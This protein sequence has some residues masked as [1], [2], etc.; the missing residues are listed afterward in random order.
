MNCL[1]VGNIDFPCN[2][3]LAILT[4]R[5][6]GIPPPAGTVFKALGNF[7]PV[8][9]RLLAIS[10]MSAA[11]TQLTIDI[12]ER[13]AFE[14]APFQPDALQDRLT[15]ELLGIGQDTL[16]QDLWRVRDRFDASI[17]ETLKGH[18]R[19]SNYPTGFCLEITK[20]V[21]QLLNQEIAAPT[22][23][24][25]HALRRF[26]AN[27]GRA[28]RIWGDLRHEYFQNAMQWGTLYIDVANDSVD[29]RKPKIEILPMSASNLYALQDFES[30]AVLAERYWKGR[31]Y[32][33]RYCPQLAPMFPLLLRFADGRYQL[34]SC[35]Q[36]LLYQNLLSDFALA[37]QAIL[38]SPYADRRLTHTEWQAL[39]R[40]CERARIADTLHEQALPD[41][42]MLALFSEARGAQLRF[43]GEQ[44]QARLDQAQRFNAVG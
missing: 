12:L 27:G 17:G 23:P 33:N 24:A 16:L 6:P 44:L 14:E 20:G 37:E 8:L 9:T 13:Q 26:I 18:A 10:S 3:T 11:M 29:R 25:M 21:M 28:K 31:I 4:P 41:V 15:R 36:M 43:A 40:Q 35:Y 38:D 34:H 30:Y 7:R 32:P 19:L 22:T 2:P 42:A 1:S 5:I 39:Q